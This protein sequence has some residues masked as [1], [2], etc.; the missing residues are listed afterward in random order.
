MND[1]IKVAILGDPHSG[2]SVFLGALTTLLPRAS[3]YLFRACLDGEGT[4]TWK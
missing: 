4:W 2:K 1:N 3:F